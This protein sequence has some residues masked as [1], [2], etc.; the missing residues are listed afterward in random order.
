MGAP[1]R[2]AVAAQR[3]QAG[4][5]GV[6]Q[7]LGT[8]E[9]HP[10][11]AF[12]LLGLVGVHRAQL[13]PDLSADLIERVAGEGDDVERVDAHGRVGGVARLGDRFG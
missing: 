1:G 12:E 7:T 4:G 13:V 10:P 11:G 2:A 5:L 3:A 8:L 9:Q 6:G